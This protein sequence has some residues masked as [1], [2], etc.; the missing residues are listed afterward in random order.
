MRHRD[1]RAWMLA[2]AVELLH[3]ADRLQRQFFQIGTPAELPRWEPPI[4]MYVNE[5]ELGLLIALPGVA[6]GRFEVTLEQQTISVR[7]ERSFGADIGASAIL[8]ME[9]P[10]GRFERRIAL[11][12]GGFRVHEML[13]ENGCLKITLERLT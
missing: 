11:P 7:G 3:A 4:D 1:A 13:L 10:Y 5:R 8:R 6:P 2:E 12:A 9:I